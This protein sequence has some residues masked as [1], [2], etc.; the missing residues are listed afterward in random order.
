MS[1]CLASIAGFALQL[2][3]MLLQQG[4]SNMTSSCIVGSLHLSCKAGDVRLLHSSPVTTA[5][6][7]PIGSLQALA[8]ASWSLVWSGMARL[9]RM[10]RKVSWGALGMFSL[11]SAHI[12]P[13]GDGS[14]AA[15]QLKRYTVM[16]PGSRL[17]TPSC[18][19]NSCMHT[20]AQYVCMH[21][22]LAVQS[23]SSVHA[24]YD[25]LP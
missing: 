17:S 18:L 11:S 15:T 5:I 9:R 13:W 6:I 4:E 20:S 10:V 21:S 22:S 8:P 2:V 12:Q 3:S 24:N 7:W 14:S 16:H 23:R 25:N 19:S 1:L